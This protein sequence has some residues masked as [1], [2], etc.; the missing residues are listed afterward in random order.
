MKI[1]YNPHSV[2]IKFDWI[3]TARLIHILADDSLYHRYIV[4]QIWHICDTYLPY[5]F[6]KTTDISYIDR[7]Y[8]SGCHT[9]GFTAFNS[10]YPHMCI[11]SSADGESQSAIL[12]LGYLHLTSSQ[13]PG[14]DQLQVD[15]TYHKEVEPS[16]PSNLSRFPVEV[17]PHLYLG[18]A[19]NSADLE[20][21]AKNGIRYILNVTPN[22]PNK[23]ET[24]DSFRYMQIPIS[25]H[26]SQNLT[27][28]F[29]EAIAFIGNLILTIF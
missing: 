5:F 2:G 3:W 16:S 29:P 13:S 14:G 12:G 1:W 21:L 22:V 19:K 7:C 23:F 25:D 24:S 27:V 15:R 9:G 11:T 28:Y 8:C 18:D 10:K 4:C 17:L 6:W 26:W 20:N